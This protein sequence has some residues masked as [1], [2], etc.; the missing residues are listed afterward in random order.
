MC[1]D[2]YTGTWI[3]IK[4]AMKDEV[5]DAVQSTGLYGWLAV[6]TGASLG[7]V[8]WLILADAACY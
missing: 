4:S 7:G 6:Q 1:A 2:T 8:A 5:T 3:D